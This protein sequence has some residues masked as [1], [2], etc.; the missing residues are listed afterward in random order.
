MI[1]FPYIH[2]V[3]VGIHD[4]LKPILIMNFSGHQGR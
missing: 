2:A 3:A 1:P 4:L